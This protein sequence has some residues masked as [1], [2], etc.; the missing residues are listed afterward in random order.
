MSWQKLGI[1]LV[2][3]LSFSGGSHKVT[4]PKK[5]VEAYDL[6]G[7]AEIE[8]EIRRVR[9]PPAAEDKAA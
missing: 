8:F 7:V 5:V 6:Y 3:K 2:G 9:R 1:T 4:I